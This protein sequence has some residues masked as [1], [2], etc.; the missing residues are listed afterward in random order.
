M[1]NFGCKF[2][3]SAPIIV[4]LVFKLLTKFI[5]R[6]VKTKITVNIFY[7]KEDGAFV[8]RF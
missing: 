8:K 5:K 6:Y 1:L 2:E 4:V 3:I 7:E